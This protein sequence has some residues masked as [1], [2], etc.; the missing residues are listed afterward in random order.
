MPELP[1]SIRVGFRDYA[2]EDWNHNDAQSEQRYGDCDKLNSKIR[3]CTAYGQRQAAETAIHEVMHACWEAGSLSNKESEE[4]VA[5]VLAKQWAQ[6]IRDN[7][8]FLEY[9]VESLA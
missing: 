6:V 9:L 2:I 7:P 8:T 3:V 4:R 1:K 5:T